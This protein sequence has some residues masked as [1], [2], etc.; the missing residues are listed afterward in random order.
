M[1]S[2]RTKPH[3]K[4]R[5]RWL[6]VSKR[7]LKTYLPIIA[8]TALV[9]SGTAFPATATKPLTAGATAN[10]AI[11]IGFVGGFV[12][13]NDTRHAEVQLAEKLRTGYSGRAHVSIFE[14][15]RRDVTAG[16]PILRGGRPAS[17]SM[18]TV[19]AH[20]RSWRLPASCKN[21]AFPSCSRFRSIAS[22]NPGKMIA[23][24]LP[25]WPA[26]LTFIRRVECFMVCRKSFQLILCGPKFW[27]TS[28]LTTRNSQSPA[29]PIPG[30]RVTF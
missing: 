20:L 12:H 3:G 2:V 28:A 21:N 30:S 8:F 15:H 27:A 19:G 25:M 24:F 26:R 5:Q 9:L 1:R 16:F 18:A 10:S 11:V 13:S 6:P 4:I 14:N 22:P 7:P 29:L 17:S 23:S